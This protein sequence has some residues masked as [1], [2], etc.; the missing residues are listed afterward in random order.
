MPYDLSGWCLARRGGCLERGWCVLFWATLL[1]YGVGVVPCLPGGLAY[2]EGVA[3]PVTRS[4][5][6]SWLL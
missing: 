2:G 4:G 5:H 1:R 3:S 6:V